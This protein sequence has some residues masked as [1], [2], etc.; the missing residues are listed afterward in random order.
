MSESTENNKEN[1][2][3]KFFKKI[4]SIVAGWFKDFGKWLGVA[5]IVAFGI[6]TAKKI[7]EIVS[8]SDRKKKEKLKSDVNDTKESITEAKETVETAIENTNTIDSIVEEA[9][10][11]LDKSSSDYVKH[12]T[13]TAKKAG[14]TKVGD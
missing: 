3:V 14:F 11:Q 6:F 2:F 4:G 9:K 12:Q 13:N 5:A 1:G 7:D 8:D 10:S